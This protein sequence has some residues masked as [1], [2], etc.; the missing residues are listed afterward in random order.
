MF[1]DALAASELPFCVLQVFGPGG[2]GKT[3]LL[4]EFARITA[5]QL[6][7]VYTDIGTSVGFVDEEREITIWFVGAALV[8]MLVTAGLS[9]AWF[10]RLP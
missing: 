9:L 7:D 10:S 1:A 5:D 6:N 4:N 8:L 3:T 2:V